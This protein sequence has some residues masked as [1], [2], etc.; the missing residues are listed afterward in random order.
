MR[1]KVWTA[2]LGAVLIAWSAATPRIPPQWHPVPHA[3]FGAVVS[4]LARA[5]LGLRPPRLWDGLRWGAGVAAPMVVAVAAATLIPPVRAGMAE[6]TLPAPAGRWLL[7]GIPIGTVWMEEAAHR[8]ALG[9]V[10]ERAFG[11]FGGQ[12]VS[13]AV[14]GLSHVPDARATGSSVPGTVLVTGAAGWMFGWLYAKSGSLAA[15][16]LVHLAVNETGAIAAL[17]VQRRRGRR[18]GRARASVV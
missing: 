10:G 9:T 7:L 1:D 5:S 4:L 11:V 8:A 3:V 16:M 17:A 15:P 12:L 18:R 6:R 2:A 13:A 14:F